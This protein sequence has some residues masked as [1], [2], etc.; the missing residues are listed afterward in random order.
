MEKLF[1]LGAYSIACGTKG[2][3]TGFKHEAV[4]FGK[5]GYRLG[6]VNCKY[7][8]RSYERFTYEDVLKKAVNTFLEDKEQEEALQ[9]I[10]ELN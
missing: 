9:L 5:G 3:R 10:N 7:C 2:T 1:S 8:N 6:K 4:L